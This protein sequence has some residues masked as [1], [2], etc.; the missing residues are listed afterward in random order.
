MKFKCTKHFN[1]ENIPR[2]FFTK[3]MNASIYEYFE[4][5]MPWL[6]DLACAT[7]PLKD[8]T[9]NSLQGLDIPAQFLHF[10]QLF[11]VKYNKII[12]R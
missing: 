5:K 8:Q 12:V 3:N 6:V 2:V 4:E 9:V 1:N 10:G 11:Q 7:W